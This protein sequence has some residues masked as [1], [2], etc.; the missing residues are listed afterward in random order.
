M[1]GESCSA[2]MARYATLYRL[3]CVYRVAA[4]KGD[5]IKH[6]DGWVRHDVIPKMHVQGGGL[7]RR[8][9]EE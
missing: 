9:Y 1:K 5:I 8:L 7:C 3:S 6:D 4:C 2:M